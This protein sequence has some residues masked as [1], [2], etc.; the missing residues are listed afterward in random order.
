MTDQ[1]SQPLVTGFS[2]L[3]V[4][5][6]QQYEKYIP[7]AFNSELTMLQKVNNLLNF[8]ST[9]TDSVNNLGTQWNDVV[10]W[11]QGT[12]VSDDVTNILTGWK[13]DGTLDAM[14]NT[15]LIGSLSSLSTVDKTSIVNAINEVDKHLTDLVTIDVMDYAKG[16]GVTDDTTSL[17][18]AINAAPA[19]AVLIFPPLKTF[20]IKNSLTF[21]RPIY[22]EGNFSTIK[23]GVQGLNNAF[24]FSS[25]NNIT[26][27]GL[28]FN[29][30]LVGRTSIAFNTCQ[31]VKV[32]GCDFTGYSADY[33]WSTYDGGICFT[34]C[35]DLL[36]EGNYFHQ[37]G[38][39]YDATTSTLN[40]CITIQGT[41]G[42]RA[43]V[44]GNVF[45]QVNQGIALDLGDSN[46][47]S[48]NIFEEV[49]DNTLYH[50]TGCGGVVIEGNSFNDKYDECLV[51]SDGNVVINGNH[52]RNTPNKFIAINGAL[53]SLVV[54]GNT[55][56][57]T[58]TVTGSFLA[59]RATDDSHSIGYCLIENN[60]FL[61]PSIN[62]VNLYP[63]LF[64]NVSRL[65]MKDNL[66]KGNF[67]AYQKIIYFNGDTLTHAIFK[68]NY[69]EGSDPS[70]TVITTGSGIASPDLIFQDNEMVNCRSTLVA[71]IVV[72]G[73]QIQANGTNLILAKEKNRIAYYSQAPTSGNWNP[74]DIVYNTAPTAG[75]NV[76]WVCISAGSPG[77]W[78]TF[79][80]IGA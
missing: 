79:G 27:K 7:T 68:D 19:N 69:V 32:I 52:F 14:I 65:L 37:H 12:G 33:G 80:T 46:I 26:I 22:I 36:V 42:D 72:R 77:T 5:T 49:H 11:L 78:K 64:G 34:D 48:G 13:D 58:S 39:Q 23:A 1:T 18:N 61:H 43:R 2:P 51:L 54:T 71:G 75:G 74:G 41:N 67:G 30:A 35:H 66:I 10:T 73:H 9:V 16:D 76:G 31:N 45:Y 24:S 20:L 21:T 50:L 38:N 44:M 57:N 17:Q 3:T 4:P 25:V 55:F 29:M 63:F 53:Q 40:R 60:V 56:D 6:I 28:F 47:I 62:D 70:S 15:N 8:L 59:Y